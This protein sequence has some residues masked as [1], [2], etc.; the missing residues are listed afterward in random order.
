MTPSRRRR[1][2]ARSRR[3]RVWIGATVALAGSV[4]VA[5]A[6]DAPATAAVDTIPI[7]L[8]G[9]EG[10]PKSV[11]EQL[12]R[13]LARKGPDYTPRTRHVRA[14]GSPV[15][16][17]RLLLE[18]S[19]YL[20]QHAHNPVNWYP[21]GDEAFDTAR[22]LGRPVLVSIGYSTCHWCHVME[23]ESF[24][25]P[26]IA[27]D[28]NRHFIAVKVDREARPDVDAIYMSALHAMNQQ[29]GWPLN[30]FVTPDRKPFFG[31]TYFPPEDARGRPEFPRVLR[32]IHQQYQ[33]N[34][35][36]VAASATSLAKAVRER[37]EGSVAETSVAPKAEVLSAARRNAAGRYDATFG[38]Q[39]GAPKFPSSMPLRFLL[40]YARRSGDARALAMVERT[41]EGMAAG[42]IYDQVGGGFHRYSTDERWLVPH[43]E[44]M[45]YDNA[46]LA[47]TYLE[48]WQVTGRTDFQRV[49]REILAYVTREMTSPDGAF[50]SATDADSLTPTGEREEGAFFT[51]TP[52]ELAEALG[53]RRAKLLTELYGVTAAGNFE[54]RNILHAARTVADVAAS[55]GRTAEEIRAIL[56]TARAELRDV[57]A[58]R[59]APLRDDKILVAWNGLMIS[60]FAQAGFAFDEPSLVDAAARAAQFV[61]SRM[62]IDGRLQ[63][64]FLDGKARGPSFL[65]DHAF[66]V[67]G[68]LDLY[69]ASAEL[70]WLREAVAIQAVQDRHYADASGGGYFETA[71][72]GEKLLA[73]EKP[74]RDGAIP[75]GNSVAGLNLLRLAEFSGDDAYQSRFDMLYAAFEPILA[76]GRGGLSEL[77][78]AV[79]YQLDAT[80]E[81]VVV[82]PPN[83]GNLAA[84]LA[85]LRTAFVPN[86][87]L[88]VVREGDELD[89][90]A[91]VV[92]LVEGRI[93]SKG[94]VTAYVCERRVCLRPTADPREFAKQLAEVKA[95]E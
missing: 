73:R 75:S 60:V 47:L 42:G 61:V 34:P 10:L 24:D 17:N 22:R 76:S 70:R 92:P 82:A 38:G 85:P 89:R 55:R 64:V 77:L 20:L 59:P 27:E 4:G 63:R 78:L 83:G 49:V 56:D 18:S 51:W 33:A 44:K 62:R 29:G 72:D 84:M 58:R 90:A 9:A 93:A 94:R 91:A 14:D 65:E 5:G 88:S 32:S 95:L 41:L 26:E 39:R 74:A 21:W 48:A 79:D 50:Y 46:L 1:L 13:A 30:V 16:T 40:R 23:E 57:R 28:L 35:E 25:T 19:P 8:P 81:I 68:L 53:E 3:A 43:F 86:R 12:A 36:R 80:K 69:E 7:A 11:R 71:D 6:V 37:L 31:G 15:Y 54:G 52:A 45:L 67:Q 66:L 87:I 2:G